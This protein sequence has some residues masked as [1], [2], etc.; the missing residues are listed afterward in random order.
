[1]MAKLLESD[2]ILPC[3]SSFSKVVIIPLP[4]FIIHKNINLLCVNWR[5]CIKIPRFW[6][7]ISIFSSS[8]LFFQDLMFHVI[9][10]S[11][12]FILTK[13]NLNITLNYHDFHW[14]INTTYITK[15]ELIGKNCCHFCIPPAIYTPKQV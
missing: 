2:A 8:I 10:F 3:E 6:Y 15:L 14:T 11:Y 5:I 1:M 13:Y 4:T 7:V 12:Y 9:L